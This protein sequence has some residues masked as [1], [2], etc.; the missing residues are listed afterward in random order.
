MTNSTLISI[1]VPSYNYEI[2]LEQALRSVADSDFDKHRM[3]IIVVDDKSSDQ[4]VELV[5]K[6]QNQLHVNLMLICN[7]TN[8]GL[9]RTRNTGIVHSNGDFLFFLDPDNY[10][11]KE[12]LREHYQVLADNSDYSAC[13]APV[14][15]FDNETGKSH[16]LISNEYF[17]FNKLATG[18]YIDSMAMYRKKDLIGLGMYDTKMPPYG[19][20]D[21]ELW[22]RMAQKGKKVYFIEG[23]PLSFY[24]SHSSNMCRNFSVSER[25]M[26]K[27]Y[28]NDK[29]NLHL[30]LEL[31]SSLENYFSGQRTYYSQLFFSP[32][33]HSNKNP[34]DLTHPTVNVNGIS[35]PLE[36]SSG[37]LKRRLSFRLSAPLNVKQLR[38]YPLNDFVYLTIDSIGFFREGKKVDAVYV[39][40]SNALDVADKK[41]LFDLQNP[42]INLDINSDHGVLIDEV[43]FQV[44]YLTCGNEVFPMVHE[45]YRQKMSMQSPGIINVALLKRKINRL[46]GRKG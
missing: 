38:F 35:V 40:S 44:Q 18:N 14:Q 43:V 4:S 33:T 32:G 46:I 41:F 7:D 30:E 27:Y 12:C 45:N 6:L 31:T 22:L 10:I 3:E 39:I 21:Y 16:S 25:N 34:D 9:I 1:I 37:N 20:E 17:D 23:K 8:I 11:A 29:Y 26:L 28:L 2:Y 13:Y 19:W 36:L 24:R 15:V 42:Q 5:K